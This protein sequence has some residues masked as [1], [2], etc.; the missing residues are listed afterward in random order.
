MKQIRHI[1]SDNGGS[2]GN[3]LVELLLSVALVVMIVPFIVRYQRDAIT[4]AQNIAIANQMTELQVALERYMFDNRT[5][6]LRTVGRNITRVELSALAPYGV[7]DEILSA[8]DDRYQLRILKSADSTGAASLQG[9]VVRASDDVSPLRTRE[10][11]R[12]SGGSMGFVDGAHAYGTYGAWHADTIDLGVTI[13]DGIIET[14]N[15]NRDNALYLWR[16]PSDNPDDAKMMSGL[17]LGGHD[18]TNVAF[19]NSDYAEFTEGFTTP[20][21]VSDKLIFQNR[22]TIDGTFSTP[23]ATVSGMLSSDAKNMDV[24]GKLTISDIAKMKSLTTDNLWV[25]KLTLGGLSVEATDD[26]SV[27]QVN[28]SLDMTSG[29]ISAM[30]VTVAF[31][32]SVSPRLAVSDAVI[33]STNSEYFWDFSSKTANFLDASFVELNRMA[34]LATLYMGDSSTSSGQLF[35]AVSANKNATVSDF[36]NAITEIQTRVRGKYRLLN[37]N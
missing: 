31:T 27:L 16:V 9:V 15:V 10:I 17:N 19:F 5:E 37:L 1:F 23:S 24:L 7:P 28:Q 30:Y 8:G 18:V 35:G 2:C 13:D 22:T 4:R 29:H 21:T 3:M 11:V 6:L 20:K 14:T 36:M 34:T 32:G 12:L 25:T 33:D 26:L